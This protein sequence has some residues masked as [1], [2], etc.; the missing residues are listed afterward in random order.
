LL[1]AKCLDAL[2]YYRHNDGNIVR[3]EVEESL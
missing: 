2:L 3:V 1:L